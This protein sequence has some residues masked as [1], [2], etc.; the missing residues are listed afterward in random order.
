[1]NL[2]LQPRTEKIL[3]AIAAGLVVTLVAFV[4][5][6][7]VL[8]RGNET[9]PATI[10]AYADGTTVT[11]PPFKYCTLYLEDCVEKDTIPIELRPGHPLQ[12]S[13]PKE[14]SSA[15]WRLLAMY[16]NTE[17]EVYVQYTPFRPGEALAVTVPT[18]VNDVPLAGVEVQ[19]PSAVVDEAGIPRAHA[20]WSLSM[21]FRE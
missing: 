1:M 8:I 17:D 5:V 18:I 4:G 12:V 21:Q 20:T 10:T 19:L 3:I 11:V 15:P 16:G 9:Q 7:T 14:I 6:L 13:L 2:Q